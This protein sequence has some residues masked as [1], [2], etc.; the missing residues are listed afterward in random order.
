MEVLARYGTES[1][2]KE[3]LIPLMD[4]RIRSAFLMTEPDI[5]SSDASNI[6]MTMLKDGND[7]V[8]NGSVW[9]VLA[10]QLLTFPDTKRR[11]GGVAAPAIPDARSTSQWARQ[12]PTT[13][14]FTSNNP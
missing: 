9:E 11:N 3:W 2:K 10:L 8:L 5:A 1:Q 14:I 4:G 6:A 7:Y 12:T 13:R